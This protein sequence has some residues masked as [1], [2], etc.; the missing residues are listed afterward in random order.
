MQLTVSWTYAG[1]APSELTSLDRTLSTALDMI[2]FG[3]DMES[4]ALPFIGSGKPYAVNV[5]APVLI[6]LTTTFLRIPHAPQSLKVLP[7]P[8]QHM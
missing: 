1:G 8:R 6:N 3:T 2:I 4:L 5:A 7:N